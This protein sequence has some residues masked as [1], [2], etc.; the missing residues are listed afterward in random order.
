MT[1][2]AII[3]YDRSDGIDVIEREDTDT[4]EDRA[5]ESGVGKMSDP[6]MA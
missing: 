4:I 6:R 3:I 2:K 1:N 5:I